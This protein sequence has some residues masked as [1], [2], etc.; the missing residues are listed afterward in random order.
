MV[1]KSD[2]VRAAVSRDDFK[3]AL[4]IAKDFT[5]ISTGRS[6]RTSRRPSMRASSL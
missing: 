4:R 5:R 2:I 3:E 6:E 1:K